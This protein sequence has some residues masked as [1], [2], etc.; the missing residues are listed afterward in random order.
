MALKVVR[1]A[2]A[3]GHSPVV[4]LWMTGELQTVRMFEGRRGRGKSTVQCSTLSNVFQS[5]LDL[6]LFN[7]E[8]NFTSAN[9]SISVD[10]EDGEQLAMTAAADNSAT[11]A[12]DNNAGAS[13]T[14]A[15][16]MATMSDK[17][18]AESTSTLAGTPASPSAGVAAPDNTSVT[19]QSTEADPLAANA[20]DDESADEAD[21]TYL[22]KATPAKLQ[23]GCPVVVG[24]DINLMLGTVV[25]RCP[26]GLYQIDLISGERVNLHMHMLRIVNVTAEQARAAFKQAVC[27]FCV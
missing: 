19:E 9:A 15:A 6:Y 8:T 12:A 17:S 14:D 7:E 21:N 11:A 26:D 4:S 20:T 10:N 22:Q 16:S 18:T 23:P 24:D 13:E 25:R 2:L 1:E 27:R 5:V 3:E